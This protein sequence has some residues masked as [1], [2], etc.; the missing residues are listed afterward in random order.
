MVVDS[1][2]AVADHYF[3]MPP[4]HARFSP[5]AGRGNLD[6]LSAQE[7]RPSLPPPPPEPR[8]ADERRVRSACAAII[9]RARIAA[10]GVL[11][12]QQPVLRVWHVRFEM[13]MSCA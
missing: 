3:G 6:S 7:S 4:A 5:V 8:V 11:G 12:V 2:S 13:R 1:Q 9:G 10:R